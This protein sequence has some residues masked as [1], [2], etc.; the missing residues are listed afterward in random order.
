MADRGGGLQ[1]GSEEE[2]NDS[3]TS[4]GASMI[5]GS[6]PEETEF[7]SDIKIF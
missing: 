2:D 6:S 1:G 7:S 5:E 4:I 3:S